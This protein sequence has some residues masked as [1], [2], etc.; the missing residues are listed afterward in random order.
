MVTV[1]SH[2]FVRESPISRLHHDIL[3]E[4][5]SFNPYVESIPAEKTLDYI[6]YTSQVCRDWRKI[7]LDS[8]SIWGNCIN[9]DQ[10]DQK[11]DSWRNLVLAR[12]GKS[13]LSITGGKRMPI[14]PCR[15][16]WNFFAIVLDEHWSRIRHLDLRIVIMSS[17]GCAELWKA[18]QR[19]TKSL[20][21]LSL[22]GS[23][24]WKKPHD[25][26]LFS[27]YAPS[28]AKLSVS[29]ALGPQIQSF[30]PPS[31]FTRSM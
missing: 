4:I 12:T 15:A 19:P 31:I 7:L 25:F 2:S 5:F 10:L 1:S 23:A 3:C 20:Q 16:V 24:R 18:L 8:P 6:H 29:F 14:D 27:G 11:S 17:S 30:H 21:T 26:Q 13:R 28:L 22:E 9:L